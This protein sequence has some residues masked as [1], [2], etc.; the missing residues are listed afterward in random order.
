M[1]GIPPGSY[2]PLIETT[3]RVVTW[4]VWGRYGPWRDREAG[5]VATLRDAR[6]DIVVLT[7]SWAKGG[8]SQGARLAGPLGLP[9]RAFSGVPAQEDQDALSGVAVLSRWPVQREASRSEEGRG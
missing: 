2:G 4:N 9:H 3:L 7:E 1:K 6:P 8:D 5:I